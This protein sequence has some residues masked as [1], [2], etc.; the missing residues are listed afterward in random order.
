MKQA[1]SIYNDFS[2]GLITDSNNINQDPNTATKLDNFIINNNGTISKRKGL[3]VEGSFDTQIELPE[4]L[5]NKNINT[6][7]WHNVKNQNISLFV[8]QVGERLYFYEYSED[9]A[10]MKFADEINLI[11]F[12]TSARLLFEDLKL[13]FTEI[14]G[15]LLCTH[16]Q[17]T[18][19]YIDFIDGEIKTHIIDDL[20]VRDYY[21]VEDGLGLFDRPTEITKEHLYNLY[22]QGWDAWMVYS[23]RYWLEF[24]PS[25]ADI[26]NHYYK[27]TLDGR[28]SLLRRY[29][30]EYVSKNIPRYTLNDDEF[31]KYNDI[32]DQAQ[33]TDPVAPGDLSL[34]LPYNDVGEYYTKLDQAYGA[35]LIDFFKMREVTNDFQAPKGRVIKSLYAPEDVTNIVNRPIVEAPPAGIDRTKFNEFNILNNIL[36]VFFDVDTQTIKLVVELDKEH[37]MYGSFSES[38]TC[39][40]NATFGHYNELEQKMQGDNG[41]YRLTEF[42]YHYKV[43][44]LTK[45]KEL[46]NYRL[47]EGLWY[48]DGNGSTND[49]EV[50]KK[51]FDDEIPYRETFSY[52]LTQKYHFITSNL[53]NEPKDYKCFI[54]T[55]NLYSQK[56]IAQTRRSMNEEHLRVTDYTSKPLDTYGCVA[57]LFGTSLELTT[58]SY[59]AS[60]TLRSYGYTDFS[61]V[62]QNASGTAVVPAYSSFDMITY[63]TTAFDW[64]QVKR[65]NVTAP[66]ILDMEIIDA[67]CLFEALSTKKG[68]LHIPLSVIENRPADWLMNVSKE[69][70]LLCYNDLYNTMRIKFSQNLYDKQ[71]LVYENMKRDEY[72]SKKLDEEY[73]NNNDF[74]G[75]KRICAVNNMEPKYLNGT[76][77]ENNSSAYQRRTRFSIVVELDKEFIDRNV[78]AL[79]TQNPEHKPY[80]DYI[81]VV[82]GDYTKYS[83][84]DLFNNKRVLIPTKYRMI[85]NGVSN[86]TTSAEWGDYYSDYQRHLTLNGQVITT[87]PLDEL[88]DYYNFNITTVENNSQVP[89]STT[90]SLYVNS[91]HIEGE[92]S[93]LDLGSFYMYPNYNEIDLGNTRAKYANAHKLMCYVNRSA[94][95]DALLISKGWK[96]ISRWD[97]DTLSNNFAT[98]GSPEVFDSYEMP[99]YNGTS[100]SATGYVRY[101]S[102]I[103]VDER[104]TPYDFMETHIEDMILNMTKSQRACWNE[105]LQVQF[106]GYKY[107]IFTIE[108]YENSNVYTD[109]DETIFENDTTN[110]FPFITERNGMIVNLHEIMNMKFSIDKTIS[111]A[112]I[113]ARQRFYR[114]EWTWEMDGEQDEVQTPAVDPDNLE[115]ENVAE[116]FRPNC[117]ASF[118]GRVFYGGINC[119]KYTNSVFYSRIITENIDKEIGKCYSQNDPTTRYLNQPLAT[120]GGYISIDDA[121]EILGMGVVGGILCVVCSNGVWG[122]SG[123]DGYFT[124]TNQFVKKLSNIGCISRESIKVV[125][126]SLVYASEYS[127]NVLQL[128]NLNADLTPTDVTKNRINDLYNSIPMSSKEYIKTIYDKVKGIIYFLY[129]NGE[130]DTRDPVYNSV[131]IFNISKQSFFTFSFGESD[132]LIKDGFINEFNYTDDMR[133]KLVCMNDETVSFYEFKD[134]T[135]YDFSNSGY[136]AE[137]VTSSQIVESPTNLLTGGNL[138]THLL[139]KENSSCVV[140]VDYDFK[141]SK[142]TTKPVEVYKNKEGKEIVYNRVML[143]GDGRNININYTSGFGKDCNILGFEMNYNVVVK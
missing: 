59:Y 90:R 54:Y 126:D 31:Q 128:N 117:S 77:D 82:S 70:E 92:N 58:H 98:T 139:N 132:Y 53:T 106:V 22:N 19:F 4:E 114:N 35:D 24:F 28:Y 110:E 141:H 48:S 47:D 3:E 36:D 108:P 11:D 64:Q 27:S 9:I 87:K 99:T 133:L 130:T 143:K 88:P 107:L 61:D 25:N 124:A 95:N 60:T 136:T 20:A 1:Y 37:G 75:V 52:P 26:V 65:K 94:E 29:A 6:Y 81:N 93:A 45:R 2:K 123:S 43:Q 62:T 104:P 57:P 100:D 49:M 121:G 80:I 86:V 122:I 103:P 129:N 15:R 55:N 10:S 138:I 69:G 33:I 23:V 101:D 134:E 34:S 142:K 102:N 44:N 42:E 50:F 84:N 40:V 115:F 14:K 125:E 30:P 56:G 140:S 109:V 73:A 72:A 76:I 137:L 39:V 7:V 111:R 8:V 116:E 13:T 5:K 46:V 118:S 120:D 12:L 89:Y 97:T 79:A 105:E 135:F 112:E 17:V 91:V 21:G 119:N 74:F 16:S 71:K 18:P 131:L 85:S 113:T 67:T 83:S 41:N 63:N 127:L 66:K 38:G 78:S 68:I 96:K 32:Y 51:K